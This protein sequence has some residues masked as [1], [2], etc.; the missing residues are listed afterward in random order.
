MPKP[1]KPDG[2][3]FKEL[4]VALKQAIA[5]ADY[6]RAHHPDVQKGD[7]VPVTVLWHDLLKRARRVRRPTCRFLDCDTRVLHEGDCCA[8]CFVAYNQGQK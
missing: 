7:G 4:V 5:V 1:R 6:C 3:I 8:S 2:D